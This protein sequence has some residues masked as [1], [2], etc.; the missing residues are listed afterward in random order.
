M[1]CPGGGGL[2]AQQRARQTW[3]ILHQMGFTVQV[4][5]RPA[6]ERDRDAVAPWLK[7]TWPRTEETVRE[8]DAWL[9][10]ADE[11]GQALRP[12]KARTWSRRGHPPPVRLRAAG[13]DRISLAGLVC[14]RP[15]HRTRLIFR[16][17]VHHGCKG[18]Q[19]GF[20][21]LNPAEGIRVQLKSRLGHL[22]PCSIDELA[23]LAR[24]R[25]KRMQ[26]RPG[27]PHGFLAERLDFD[28]EAGM[29]CA[30]GSAS[31]LARLKTAMESVMTSPEAVRDIIARAE[32]ISLKRWIT[33]RTGPRRTV[34]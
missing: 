20:R 2:T 3:P 21:D 1:R 25:L 30:A 17:L 18:E 31:D 15:G 33:S 34:C 16:M 6:P 12:P 11:A 27:L 22:A 7:Q 32:R 10:S 4:P 26:Y 28:S 13:S 24:T 9:C 23:D 29:F 19:K 5:V 8:R 14:R